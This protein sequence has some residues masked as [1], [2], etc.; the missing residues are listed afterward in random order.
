MTAS[1]RSTPVGI[2]GRLGCERGLT[3]VKARSD[4]C[5][6]VSPCPIADVGDPVL[7]T[8]WNLRLALLVLAGTICLDLAGAPLPTDNPTATVA[9]AIKSS[10]EV[11][12]GWRVFQQNC[13]RCHGPDAL[14]T[15]KAPN[16]LERVKPMSST[17]FIGTVL[18]RYKWVLPAG[19]ASN[20]SGAPDV[21]IQGIADRQRATLMM[22]A[23]ENEPAVRAHVGDLYDYLQARANGALPPGR[24]PWARQK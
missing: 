6:I 23:W 14:G 24:P 8:S 16:L 7:N 18:Q 12:M 4:W 21:L 20:E 1:R 5:G 19:E 3:A 10:D 17:R 15:D 13:A 9:R 2:P 22:P 11:Y